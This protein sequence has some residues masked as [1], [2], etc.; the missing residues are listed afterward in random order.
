MRT[1]QSPSPG[2]GATNFARVA[3][4]DATVQAMIDS[5]RD[6]A[7]KDALRAALRGIERPAAAQIGPQVWLLDRS[8]VAAGSAPSGARERVWQGWNFDQGRRVA[9]GVAET[10][11]EKVSASETAETEFQEF[12][13]S[14]EIA[15]IVRRL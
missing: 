9:L 12:Q 7:R 10:L 15:S 11:K 6:K 4:D 8:D 14:P 2:P 13:I 3:L 1:S 5:E